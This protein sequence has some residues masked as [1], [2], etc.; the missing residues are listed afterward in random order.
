MAGVIFVT[1]R[2]FPALFPVSTASRPYHNRRTHPPLIPQTGSFCCG[3][4]FRTSNSLKC[5]HYAERMTVSAISRPSGQRHHLH[6]SGTTFPAAD[7]TTDW[8]QHFAGHPDG[9]D[10]YFDAHIGIALNIHYTADDVGTA[11]GLVAVVGA[12]LADA[13]VAAGMA[14]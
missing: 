2:M 4:S 12:V 13:F 8:G 14:Q 3:H 11:V 6:H 7:Y 9:H 5:V 1:V 10:S